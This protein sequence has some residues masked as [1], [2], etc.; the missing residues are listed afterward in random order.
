MN[1]Y[2]YYLEED[3]ASRV[4][5]DLQT[6]G[7]V[8]TTPT[9]ASTKDPLKARF[10]VGDS[11]R[12]KNGTAEIEVTDVTFGYRNYAWTISGK[13]VNS[14]NYITQRNQDDFVLYD[15]EKKM[16]NTTKLYTWKDTLSN[17][18]LYGHYLA[19]NSQ[20]EWVMEVKGSG[21]IVAVAKNKVEEVLPYTISVKF[22]DSGTTYSYLSEKDKFPVGFYLVK[23]LHSDGWQIAQVTAV[24][25]K[26]NKAT[27]EFAPIGKLAVDLF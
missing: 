13:Y 27:K 16:T 17:F 3:Y 5:K 11:V 12:L 2:D 4:Y 19:T 8:P 14:D 1:K 25:T 9:K 10:K 6:R 22:S 20:G 21:Q 7:W 18:D 24:D 23:A 15:G 26:S